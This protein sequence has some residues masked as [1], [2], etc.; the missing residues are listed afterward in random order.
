MSSRRFAALSSLYTAASKY[1]SARF[2]IDTRSLALFRLLIGVTILADIL[3]RIRHFTYFYTNEGVVTAAHT[4]D[5]EFVLSLFHLSDEPFFAALFF[6]LYALVAVQF[7]L[8]WHTRLATVL[9]FV[10]V[11]SLH[12]RNPLVLNYGDRLLRLLLL[13]AIFLPL[14]ERWSVDAVRKSG[15]PRL[16]VTSLASVLI[17]CQVALLHLANGYQK[18]TEATWFTDPAVAYI[19]ARDHTTF[20][21]GPLVREYTTLLRGVSLLWVFMLLSAW[22]LLVLRGRERTVFSL[23]FVGFHLS[24]LVTRPMSIAPPVAVAGL[25]LFLQTSFWEDLQSLA[26]F[27]GIEHWASRGRTR[28]SRLA[29]T[30]ERPSAPLGELSRLRTGLYYGGL[31]AAVTFVVLAPLLVTV[32]GFVAA[33]DGPLPANSEQVAAVDDP[34][35]AASDA[36][37]IWQSSWGMHSDP[38]TLD[39]Y[40]VFAAETTDGEFLDLQNDRPLQFQR[41]SESLSGQYESHRHRKFLSE[42]QSDDEGELTAAFAD[43]LCEESAQD[44]EIAYVNLYVVVESFDRDSLTNLDDRDRFFHHI[45]THA[46][47][48]EEA[49]LLEPDDDGNGFTRTEHPESD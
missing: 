27:V 20:L 31:L 37:Y 21:L 1:A 41:P 6:L 25:L 38:S 2:A 32:T 22:A 36:L 14:G 10:F 26:T 48:G 45:D 39:R 34:A 13:W 40:Y 19:L 46:C 29:S 28:L 33:G 42:V 8:G 23:L 30:P 3:M 9:L 4:L 15:S 7:L 47:T 18:A 49:M 24:L 17:L 16:Q 44:E 5:G 43:S 11:V 12:H 35:E